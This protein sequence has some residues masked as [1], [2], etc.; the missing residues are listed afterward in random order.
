MLIPDPLGIEPENPTNGNRNG[1]FYGFTAEPFQFMNA[2][3]SERN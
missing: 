2:A 3:V 1:S